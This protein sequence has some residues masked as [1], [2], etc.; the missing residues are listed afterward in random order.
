MAK[1]QEEKKE[2]TAKPAASGTSPREKIW[3]GL[4]GWTSKNKFYIWAF[5]IPALIMAIVYGIFEVYPLGY[6]FGV[7][8][9]NYSVL[10]LDL[11]GQYVYYFEELRDAIW[12]NGSIFYSWSRNLSGEFM[13][14]IGYYLA[15]PFTWIVMILP[16]S[17]M[18]ESLLIMQLCKVGAIG[19]TFS[20]YLQKSRNI[21]MQ[22]LSSL[23]FSTLFALCAYAVIQLMDPMWIDGLIY[24]PLIL[25]GI[26]YLV[27]DGRKANYII[28]LALMFIA[29]FYIGFM[30][31]IYSVL[32]FLYYVTLGTERE[33]RKLKDGVTS[34]V[35]FG[36][37]SIVAAMCAAIMLLPVYYSLSLGK[38]DFTEPNYSLSLQF[39]SVD[40]LSKLLPSSYDTV[41]NE[42]LPEIYCGTLTILMIPL[43][44]MNDKIKAKHKIG[45]AL[46]LAVMFFSMYIKPIDMLW[47]GGQV[48]N[49]LPYRY[50]FIMSCILLVMAATAFKNIDGLKGNV[51]GGS[52]FGILGYLVYAETLNYENIDTLGVI[53]FTV[54][55]VLCFSILVS[56]YKSNQS[57]K[58]IQIA[59]LLLVSGEL[60][61]NSI[62]TLK[63]IDKDVAYS[64]YSSYEPQISEGRAAVAALEEKDDSL[65]RSEKVI[66]NLRRTVN[67]PMAWGLKGVTHS[68]SVMNSKMI[69]FLGDVGYVSR[70]HYTCYNG[71]T[72]L[73]DSL[74]GIKYVFDK[75]NS[76]V[77]DDSY[78]YFFS[79]NT[80]D[81]KANTTSKI[82]V[83][84]NNDALSIGY[85]VDD[86]I[87][88]VKDNITTSSP[89]DNQSALLSSM[90]GES[91]N[92]YTRM[93]TTDEPILSNLTVQDAIDQ[94]KYNAGAGD[95]T[96][97][98]HLVAE[99][100]DVLYLY[101][102]AKYEKSVNLW[103]GTYNEDISEW[104]YPTF[105]GQ[106]FE[107]D[108]YCILKVGK[109]QPGEKIGIRLTVANEYTY[110][111]DQIF[112]YLNTAEYEDAMDTLKSQQ[113][114]I[115]DWSDAHIKG[116]INAKEGQVMFTSI[117]YEK[118]WTVKVDGKKVV[119]MEVAG[120]FIAVNVGGEG[121]HKIDMRFFPAGLPLGIVLF[122]VGTAIVVV[123]ILIDG[124]SNL[125]FIKILTGRSKK[126]A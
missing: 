102:P 42:G 19:V 107:N 61:T 106:Y 77:V 35:R 39:R 114:Q 37:C 82:D 43:F 24:L 50:S 112:A 74:L 40:I 7:K 44:F 96:I 80:T 123:F 103:L 95:A 71:S 73:M 87:L 65:Y 29:N 91:K 8:D 62:E 26:E 60:I 108:N 15:S 4:K 98:Y 124:K 23:I 125:K 85:M 118:G 78:E 51:I 52:F 38:F 9:P 111:I 67:D 101:F 56:A 90:I 121:T 119:P 25:L 57:S 66:K 100:D 105:L 30:I 104:S 113:L 41:R 16:R 48:P 94:V 116:E 3:L 47:H 28:P 89:F 18:T 126:K 88:T 34:C 110:M 75:N 5:I 59:I 33:D 11:N 20:L 86:D 46:L 115:T 76:G 64:K 53:W 14:I 6:L 63:D 79:T 27:D 32:Y 10:V 69:D 17:I 55:C 2:A 54:G 83:F 109:F 1:A 70:G 97:D 13:G 81:T 31:A 117:P 84:R 49:W 122:L 21:K 93:F 120:G 99:T 22:P 72:R 68:S 12:G 58:A 36:V 92:F 45:Q